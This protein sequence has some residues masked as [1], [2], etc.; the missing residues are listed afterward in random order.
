MAGVDCE[1]NRPTDRLHNITFRRCISVNNSGAG[2]QVFPGNL[3]SSSLPVK[4]RFED[5]HVLGVGFRPY[6]TV[7]SDGYYFNSFGG[8]GAA[9]TVVVDGGTVRGTVSFGAAVYAH[10]TN[11]PHIT[12]KDVTIDHVAIQPAVFESKLNF[13]NGAMAIAS[14]G[15]KLNGHNLGGVTLSNV[16]VIEARQRP[17]LVVVGTGGGGVG[18]IS[19]S[20]TV[21]SSQGGCAGVVGGKQSV[22]AGAEGWS[23]AVTAATETALRANLSIRCEPMH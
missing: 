13:S 7:V 2:F 8:K 6:G 22:V 20:I 16:T 5:C 21:R 9:G 12:F 19:G 3:N 4:I 10:G 17:L 11:D 1:P 15:N 23:P 18:D 14:L